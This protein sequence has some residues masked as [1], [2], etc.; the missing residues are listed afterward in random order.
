[1]T[2]VENEID[3]EFND[4][5]AA[6]ANA[7]RL[8]TALNEAHTEIERLRAALEAIAKLRPGIVRDIAHEA[9]ADAEGK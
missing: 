4:R 8:R 3:Q 1:M 9:L 2:S 6:R 5:N 7:R